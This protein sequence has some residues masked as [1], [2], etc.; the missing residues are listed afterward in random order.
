MDEAMRFLSKILC[1]FCTFPFLFPA[2]TIAQNNLTVA[3][4]IKNP[5]STRKWGLFI[6]AGGLQQL[7]SFESCACKSNFKDGGGLDLLLGGLY[8]LEISN[9]LKAGIAGGFNYKTLN[10]SYKE[11]ETI[12]ITSNASGK[13]KSVSVWFKNEAKS[14]F[15]YLPIIP[16][17]KF[18]PIEIFF[19]KAGFNFS[20]Y[21]NSN[22]KQTKEVLD[23]TVISSSGE[24]V[25][26]PVS[27]SVLYDSHLQ[28]VEPFYFAFE[29]SLGF[30]FDLGNNIIFSPEF[31]YSLQ[32][33][34]SLKD[35]DSFKFSIFRLLLL[36]QFNV[37][38][39]LN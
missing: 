15:M 18:S 38:S 32:L 10:D 1:I 19:I 20:F 31:Q 2:E 23:K 13:T 37:T 11:K 36:L 17:L 14:S 7:G 4:E 26:L 16:Y 39:E 30:N 33:T 22:F 8:E 3:S 12:D 6:G 34:P 5:E 25:S 35:N 29:P 28:N 27:Y 21:I 24:V 9:S